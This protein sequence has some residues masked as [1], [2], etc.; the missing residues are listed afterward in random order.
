MFVP[1]S[2]RTI[3]D[4]EWRP[5]AAAQQFG[6]FIA[7]GRDRRWPAVAP[8][9]Y[10]LDDDEVLVHFAAPNPVLEA[11]AE[12][13]SAVLSVAGDWAF[14]PSDWKV[15]GDEDPLA[16]IPTTYYAAVQ[17]RGRA[18]VVVEPERI[19]GVLRRQ[20]QR[21]QPGTSI[22]DPL[23]THPGKLRA[24]RAVVLTVEEVVAKFK[25]GGNVDVEHRMAVIDRLE[26]RGGPGDR[27]AAAHAR[28][29]IEAVRPGT[30]G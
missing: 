2:D 16:G 12:E 14:I 15:I 10:V 24:I 11:L 27:A 30:D 20:L 21:L 29:R 18:E 23:E 17:L 4:S 7:P 22:G 1:P 28:R 25:F 9:Q 13:P 19:A 3:G 26:E 6:Q 8:T 5:F